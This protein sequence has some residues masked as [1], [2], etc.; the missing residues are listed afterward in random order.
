MKYIRRT[1]YNI[2]ED[3]T[4]NLLI[5]R[6][7]LNRDDKEYSD[8]FFHPTLENECYPELLDNI[9]EGY[10][11]LMKHLMHEDRILICIDP[12]VDGYTSAAVL[13]N[14]LN[15]VIKPYFNFS[16][17]Y[18]IPDGKE[19]G[20][21]TL[22]SMFDT[23]DREYDLII[24][25]DS[26]SNDYEQHKILKEKGYDILVIDHH[27][28]EKY[29]ENA[30]VINNQLSKNYPNKDLSGVGVVYKFLEYI[31][32]H[33]KKDYDNKLPQPYS[34]NYLDLVALG[35]ISDMM[36]MTSLENRFICDVGLS[37]IKNKF[38]KELIEKQSYS[39][40]EGELT[41]IGVA[42]Y[43]TPLIN[44]LIR[45]GSLSEKEKLFQAFISPDITVPSTKRGEKGQLEKVS[46]QSV[47]NC[48][49]AKSRQN[50]EKEKAL[51]LLDIQI[52]EN[53]LENNKI[54]ILNADELN[55]PNTLTGLCAMGV[56]AKYK[57]PVILGR[58]SPDGYLKGSGRGRNESELKDFRQ[59]LIDSGLIDFAEG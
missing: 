14:Y 9:E 6:H 10:E 40:G 1:S 50:R 44:A 33:F 24:M 13:Y 31:D 7:I 52:A 35:E 41:Q 57:K 15:D 47:R 5:D 2:K 49:N 27:L 38:F 23:Y 19:H 53:C 58:I 56:S 30:V 37:N 8:K 46:T 48:V 42:F 32:Y 16:L 29:S 3:F 54:L 43:I 34:R 22:M 51:E 4:K 45:V 18:H 20:L 21:R 39:I 26:S 17:E 55:T 36:N 12:D 28:C 59:F 25:P 11:L